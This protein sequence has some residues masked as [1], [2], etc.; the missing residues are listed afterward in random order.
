MRKKKVINIDEQIN[1]NDLFEIASLKGC[2]DCLCREC[3][4][5]W[6]NRC[7]YGLCYDDKRAR[8]KPYDIAHT[9]EPLRK[10]WSAWKGD[11]EHWCRGGVCY[12]QK[13]CESYKHYKGST[14][15]SCLMSNVQVFQDGFIRCSIIETM[16]C[17]EC[18]KRFEEK[19]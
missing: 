8:E 5:W 3:L 2:K 10:S 6:S 13:I 18:Y 16:G 11:Q 17:E 15:K 19:G 12:P 14:V 4:Y 9:N 1:L 7:P